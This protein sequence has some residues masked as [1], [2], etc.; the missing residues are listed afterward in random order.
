MNEKTTLHINSAIDDICA[1]SSERTE[2]WKKTQHG[3]VEDEDLIGAA[4]NQE[5]LQQMKQ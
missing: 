3:W 5:K 1:A 2:M 4:D